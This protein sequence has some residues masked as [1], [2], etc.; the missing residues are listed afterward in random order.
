MAE[1]QATRPVGHTMLS[2]ISTEMVRAMKEYYGKGPTK[3][4]SYMLDDFLLVV[5]RGGVTRAEET[6]LSAGQ[7]DAVRDFRQQFQNEMRER[8][9][10]TVEQLTGRRVVNYQSQVLFDPDIALEVFIFDEPVGEEEREAT[11]EAVS[12]PEAGVGEAPEVQTGRNDVS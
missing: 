8:L 4:K 3:A 9:T 2:R 5:M 6:L 1:D 11:A 7:E 10:S 12:D